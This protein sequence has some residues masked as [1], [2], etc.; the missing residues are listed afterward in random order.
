MADSMGRA[1][2]ELAQEQGQPVNG[3]PPIA[4]VKTQKERTTLSPRICLPSVVEKEAKKAAKA[5]KF[6]AKESKKV[7]VL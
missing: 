6:E 4:K 3:E 5:A 1:N 7:V 2:S